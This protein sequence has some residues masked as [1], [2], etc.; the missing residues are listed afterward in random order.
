MD[1][2]EAAAAIEDA[3]QRFDRLTDFGFGV[4]D[5]RSLCAAERAQKLEEERQA[6]SPEQ[7]ATAIAFL[8]HCEPTK[9]LNSDSYSLKHKAEKWGAKN[10]YESY[11]T[12]GALIV[13]A[14]YLG[15]PVAHSTGPNASIGVSKKSLVRLAA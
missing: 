15:F 12:N 5:E 4:Y 10:G 2:G 13:A 3:K 6:F 14:V 9:T 11:V 7:V 1:L 8:R